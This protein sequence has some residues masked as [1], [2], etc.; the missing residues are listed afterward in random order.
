MISINHHPID[1]AFPN[2][3]I[4]KLR[5][6]RLQKRS[7]SLLRRIFYYIKSTAFKYGEKHCKFTYEL[8]E[9]SDSYTTQ[10]YGKILTLKLT[11]SNCENDFINFFGNKN[12]FSDRNHFKVLYNKK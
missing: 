8:L 1:F 5:H 12:I 3:S 11:H 7:S 4:S 2:D 9:N 6:R 10:M